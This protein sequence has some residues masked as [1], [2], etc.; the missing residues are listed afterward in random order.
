MTLRKF[1]IEIGGDAIYGGWR[2][3]LALPRNA[4]S[5][6]RTTKYGEG[7]HSRTCKTC[8]DVQG[9]VRTEYGKVGINS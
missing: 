1:V 3:A 9:R 4:S 5:G 2:R 7:N 6:R 8:K